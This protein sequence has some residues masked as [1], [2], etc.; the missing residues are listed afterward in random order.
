MLL[1]SIVVDL[2]DQIYDVIPEGLRV[3][4]GAETI[5]NTY[6]RLTVEVTDE[7]AEQLSDSDSVRA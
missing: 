7:D 6:L 5:D 4:I 2:L 1:S 3:D